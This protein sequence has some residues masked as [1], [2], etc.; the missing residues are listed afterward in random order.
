VALVL[1]LNAPTV[2]WDG[3]L[4]Q[5]L[6]SG[7]A[8]SLLGLSLNGGEKY[9]GSGMDRVNG[10]EKAGVMRSNR[11]SISVVYRKG[12]PSLPVA[13]R[14]VDL[15]KEELVSILTGRQLMSFSNKSLR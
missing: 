10:F 4:T 3:I 8:A 5:I 7:P 12:R 9:W 1:G 11:P 13:T 14:L 2:L 15:P 6:P